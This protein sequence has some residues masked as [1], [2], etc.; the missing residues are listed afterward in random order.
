MKR[1]LIA[2]L[3]ITS[4]S[5]GCIFNRGDNRPGFF[6]GLYNRIHRNDVGAPCMSG[7]C[8]QAVI[9]VQPQMVQP[10]IVIPQASM[11]PGCGS[12]GTEI[13]GYPEYSMGYSE[14][15]YQTDVYDG[16]QFRGEQIVPQSTT[17]VPSTVYE[18]TP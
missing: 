13:V 14:P 2:A 7:M 1:L 9:P 8:Q 16:M 18:S 15:A 5:S 4:L 12:C 6:R 3:A 11:G 17:M 10:Q